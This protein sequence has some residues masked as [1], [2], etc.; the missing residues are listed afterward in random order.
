MVLPFTVV[1]PVGDCVDARVQRG[2][3]VILRRGVF[4]S[5][6]IHGWVHAWLRHRGNNV[7]AH[8]PLSHPH[9]HTFSLSPTRTQVLYVEEA[10]RS[11]LHDPSFSNF[12]LIVVDDGSTDGS[13]SIIA[14]VAAED[15]M[16]RVRVITRSNGGIVAALNDGLAVARGEYVR[17]RDEPRV[18][19]DSRET[20]Q[21]SCSC[22]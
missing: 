1:A 11:I 16:R 5:K 13:A 20:I 22:D 3:R 7:R 8:T 4:D 14:R 6:H 17:R 10:L 15:A 2:K 21:C 19:G 18:V 9:T 12:E